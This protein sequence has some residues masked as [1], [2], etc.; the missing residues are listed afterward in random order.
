[1]QKVGFVGLGLMGEPMAK[2]LLKAGYPLI[3][4]ARRKEV[5]DEMTG[6]GGIFASSPAEVANES[7]IVITIV[8]AD[9]QVREVWSGKNGLFDSARSGQVFIDM[10][11]ISPETSRALNEACQSKG[12][13]A[14]DAPVSGGPGGAKSGTLTI[15]VGGE[16]EAVERVRPVLETLGKNIYHMGGAGMGQAAKLCNQLLSGGIMVLTSEAMVLAEK[17]GLDRELLAE[18]VGVSSGAST[19]LAARFPKFVLDDNFEAGFFLELMRKDMGLGLDQGRREG[20]RLEL[21][22]A[23]QRFYDS[24]HE[25]GLGRE[26]FCAVYK[27]VKSSS[28]EARNE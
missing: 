9:P 8:T 16:S 20:I 10:S 26:D 3:Y 11:T 23:A 28:D 5:I 15:F 14:V 25:Q 4:F 22:E 7:D 13:S 19:V 24:A 1:M 18:A 12:I 6:A 2:N 21:S 17:I 27:A